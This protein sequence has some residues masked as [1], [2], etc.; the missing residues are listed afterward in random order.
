M[1]KT[2]LFTL[3]ILFVFAANSQITKGN[4]LMGG[5]ASF[6]SIRYNVLGEKTKRTD[7]SLAP[8][9]GYFFA[10]K[11][12]GGLKL[13]FSLSKYGAESINGDFIY[14][15]NNRY[16]A[17]PFLRYYFLEEAQPVNL[18]AE[19][20]FAYGIGKANQ[21]TTT[22]K[23]YKYSLFAGPAVYFNS[24]VALEFTL[25]YYHFK[26]V[27]FDADNSTLMFGIGLQIHLE[28]DNN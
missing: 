20:N 12:A 2:T 9:I 7:I 19:G 5:S 1:K 6:A 13:D 8:A 4:W 15:T 21:S 14:T 25:G 27:G 23:F 22:D 18:F 10:D 26:E 28:K 17:G 24:S 3:T 11:V 16:V